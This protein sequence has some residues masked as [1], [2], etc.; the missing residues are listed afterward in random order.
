MWAEPSADF[1]GTCDIEESITGLIRTDGPVISFNGAWA[2]NI[3]E[4][5]MFID[6]MGDKG[7]IR[8]MYRTGEF[9]Y[10]STKNGMLSSTKYTYRQGDAFQNE[11]D[12]YIKAV[13]EGNDQLPS[14]ININIETSR[15]MDAIYRSAEQHRE[16]TL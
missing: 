2:Q 10:Y 12:A 13:Q 16:I 11:I 6:F 4:D 9:T 3:D 14:N 15:I 5:E 8:Y 1:N 7:G